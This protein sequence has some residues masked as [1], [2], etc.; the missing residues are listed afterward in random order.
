V[1]AN[2]ILQTGILPTPLASFQFGGAN[3]NG[4]FGAGTTVISGD[5]FTAPLI[6]AADGFGPGNGQAEVALAGTGAAVVHGAA[7]AFQ[8]LAF[9]NLGLVVWAPG[10]TLTVTTT[11]TA[12]ADP[13]AFDDFNIL[14]DGTL[15]QAAGGGS[16]PDFAFVSAEAPEPGT[17]CS[18]LGRCL[19]LALNLAESAPNGPVFPDPRKACGTPG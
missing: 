3:G 4:L 15:P 18:W 12:Y 16:L 6:L 5:I 9:N 1:I 2:N 7:G 10:T 8:G 13:A 11:L 19:P 14:L 17:S